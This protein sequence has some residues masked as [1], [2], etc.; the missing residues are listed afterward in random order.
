MSTTKEWLQLKDVENTIRK[1]ETRKHQI[2]TEVHAKANKGSGKS[3]VEEKQSMT[4]EQLYVRMIQ[5]GQMQEAAR[6][7][8]VFTGSKEE[9][10]KLY[11]SAVEPPIYMEDGKRFKIIEKI[12]T[13][14]DLRK[15]KAEGEE[16]RSKHRM[17]KENEELRK[18]KE[19]NEQKNKRLDQAHEGDK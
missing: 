6:Q 16:L 11:K 3:Y 7:N 2:K 17:K 12:K 9:A 4:I 5:S 14:D 8:Q 1:K 18:Y 19:E 15:A 13:I 10:E